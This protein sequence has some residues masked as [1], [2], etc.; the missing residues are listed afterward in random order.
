VLRKERR[1]DHDVAVSVPDLHLF[2]DRI[3]VLVDDIVST[4]RTMIE[5][6]RH[7]RDQGLPPAVCLA[8]HALLSEEGY[9]RLKAIASAVVTTNAVPHP[10]NAIDLAPLIGQSISELL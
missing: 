1:G 7:L 3:P 10:S 8:V 4:G 2:A 5:T 9:G 6:A